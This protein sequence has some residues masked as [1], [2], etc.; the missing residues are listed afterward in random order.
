MNRRNKYNK[1]KNNLSKHKHLLKKIGLVIGGTGIFHKAVQHPAIAAL[2]AATTIV[3]AA[4][5]HQL[6]R[7]KKEKEKEDEN[8]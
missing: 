7:K 8:S 3:A 2:S 1:I 6:K 5:I 4:H